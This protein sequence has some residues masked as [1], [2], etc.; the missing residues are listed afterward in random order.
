MLNPDRIPKSLIPLIPMVEKW[1][2]GDDFE[3]EEAVSK[4]GRNELQELVHSIDKIKD[5][6]LYGW[7][8]TPL[9]PGSTPSK[10]YVAF[11]CFTMALDSA[12]LK[13]KRM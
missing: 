4:A 12:K 9:S 10:E 2:I 13:L 8:G 6:D 7:L 3:R 5:V 11:T 1:G